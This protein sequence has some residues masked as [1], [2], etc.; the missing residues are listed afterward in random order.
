M[1]A[2]LVPSHARAELDARRRRLR[3]LSD[4]AIHA[5]ELGLAMELEAKALLVDRELARDPESPSAEYSDFWLLTAAPA[6]MRA[7]FG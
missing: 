2:V 4:Q 6:T 1:P 3:E 5:D 7:R